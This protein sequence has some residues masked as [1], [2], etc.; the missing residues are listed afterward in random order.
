MR[1]I[2]LN[3]DMGEYGAP[4]FLARE[5][6]FMPLITSVNIACGAHAGNPELMRRTARL[7]AQH[8]IAIG[9]HPGFPHAGDFGRQDRQTSP[10]EIESL[11]SAQLKTLSEVLASDHL[12]LSHVKLH[13][14]LYNLAAQDRMI[15]DAVTRAVAS[16]DR[17]LL[18][19]ALAGS[20]LVDRGKAAGLTTVQEAFADRAYG[21]DGTLVPRSVPGALLETE[22]QVRR[23]LHDI[24][25]GFVTSA[26]GLQV[27]LQVDSLC[28]HLDTP[29]A[30]EF[31][32]LI[33]EEIRSTGIGIVKPQVTQ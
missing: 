4:D 26:D 13:G 17:Q 19:F 15:A 33:R 9:A 2:D 14:A 8:G 6:Q 28:V 18:L 3:S 11:V 31:V 22:Q 20:V 7:A 29:H 21:S 10:E 23:Q 30:V 25:N 1:T 24:L 16:L 12:V 32:Y 5:V 27:P